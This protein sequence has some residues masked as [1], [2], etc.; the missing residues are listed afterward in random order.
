MKQ[1]LI[2]LIVLNISNDLYSQYRVKIYTAAGY[3]SFNMGDLKSLQK[4]LLSDINAIGVNGSITDSYPAYLGFQLGFQIPLKLFPPDEVSLGG[5]MEYTSTGGRVHYADYSGEIKVDQVASA[6]S[7]GAFL[8]LG[9]TTNEWF[10]LDFTVSP[11][12][13]FSNLKNEFLFKIGDEV[14]KESFEFFSTS[15]AL[16]AGLIPS[17]KLGDFN[18]GLPISYMLAFPSF[19]E[20]YEVGNAFL[21]NKSNNRV[22]INWSGVRVGL[23]VKYTF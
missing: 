16:E 2:L 17:I 13:I 18:I 20:Y 1:I 23:M 4:E 9:L 3:N 21:V 22:T 15:V 6:Y 7:F 11:R 10:M 14:Q 5:F 12:L 19:L 8:L